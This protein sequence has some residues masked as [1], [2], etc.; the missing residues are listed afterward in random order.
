[1]NTLEGTGGIVKLKI[2]IKIGKESLVQIIV[3]I[4]IK[5]LLGPCSLPWLN[6]ICLLIN[7]VLKVIC[8]TVTVSLFYRCGN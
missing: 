8:A 2:G 6:A 3:I 5:H 1:M 7:L 4:I